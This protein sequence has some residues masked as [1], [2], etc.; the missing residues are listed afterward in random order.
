MVIT[1]DLMQR[2]EYLISLKED[3]RDVHFSDFV[4]IPRSLDLCW[5]VEFSRIAW[6]CIMKAVFALMSLCELNVDTVVVWV[7]C[8]CLF[9]VIDCQV[10]GKMLVHHLGVVYYGARNKWH[11]FYLRCSRLVALELFSRRGR[12][13]SCDWSAQGQSPNSGPPSTKTCRGVNQSPAV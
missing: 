11:P 4:F 9:V 8:S 7:G 3:V 5:C 10:K 13:E 6:V 2:E 12:L 1:E